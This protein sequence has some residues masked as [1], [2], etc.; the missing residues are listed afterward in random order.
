MISLEEI[1]L[2]HEGKNLTIKL[3]TLIQFSAFSS[4]NSAL[5]DLT[6]T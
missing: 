5:I 6:E 4:N 3:I 1:N 2:I